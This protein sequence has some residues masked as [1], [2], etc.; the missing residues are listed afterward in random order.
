MKCKYHH[1]NN[2]VIVDELSRNKQF[3]S[4]RCKNI[5]N[6]G[7][8]R[9]KLKFKAVKYKGGKCI[10]CGYNSCIAAL[11]FHHT[12]PSSKEFSI[13]SQPH[14]RSW[15]KLKTEIDKC[16]L[17]CSNCHREIEFAKYVETKDYFSEIEKTMV[18]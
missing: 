5:Y 13:S 16:E 8:T 9:W 1:C 7:K 4:P 11:E 17:L 14:T 15:E 12:D 18:L 10:K 2:D 3:C 6:V